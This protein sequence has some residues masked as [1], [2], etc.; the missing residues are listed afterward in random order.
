MKYSNI[1]NELKKQTKVFMCV[2]LNNTSCLKNPKVLGFLGH[3]QS[4]LIPDNWKST[5]LLDVMAFHCKVEPS[6]L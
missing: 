4:L 3:C 2:S 1:K 6:A 5:T